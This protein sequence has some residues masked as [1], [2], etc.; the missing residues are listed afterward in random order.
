MARSTA[1]RTVGT[2]LVVAGV[3]AVLIGVLGACSKDEP[4]A[5][6]A[7]TTTVDPSATAVPVTFDDTPGG[8]WRTKVS[9]ACDQLVAARDAASSAHVPDGGDPSIE[10]LV[11]YDKAYRPAV[12][13]F[14]EAVRATEPPPE[15]V[16]DGD[17]LA[18]GADAL[19][20]E[21]QQAIDDKAAAQTQLDG[22]GDSPASTKL[23]NAA[24][25][26]AIPACA[27]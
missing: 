6:V 10:Q 9:A 18:S 15:L 17:D 23:R 2:R 12:V 4:A 16:S 13:T 5:P 3:S 24:E 1:A 19:A 7:P 11:E 26:L 8:R 21:L 22:H 20:V 25:A 14:A 27:F